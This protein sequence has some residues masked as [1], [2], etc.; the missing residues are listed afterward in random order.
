MFQ[1]CVKSYRNSLMD[2]KPRKYA[3]T[4]QI[5]RRGKILEETRDLIAEFGV[6]GVT[7]RDLAERSGVALATLYNNYGSKDALI[8][9]AV[10]ELFEERLA[11]LVDL[12]PQADPLLAY[13]ARLRASVSEVHRIPEYAK[14]MTVLYFTQSGPGGIRDILHGFAK[15]G[16]LAVVEDLAQEGLL[17]DAVVPDLLAD[18]ITSSNYAVIAK[19]R[20]GHVPDEAL[21]DRMMY[22]GLTLI[23]GSARSELQTRIQA[24]LKALRYAG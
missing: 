22:T 13:E 21:F 11:N 10:Q 15:S 5:E 24:R 8:S 18:E 14:V 2:A 6:E 19:W 1:F 23:A 16:Y 3:S 4:R 20:Q 17:L 12:P 7:M 9:E